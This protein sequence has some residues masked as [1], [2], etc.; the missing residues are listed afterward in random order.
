MAH[1]RKAA[2]TGAA[3]TNASITTRER[4][5]EADDVYIQSIN[6]RRSSMRAEFA[7]NLASVLD[8]RMM[9]QSKLVDLLND[10]FKRNKIENKAGEIRET[11]AWEV[12]RWA[13]GA[14]LPDSD[15]VDA[16]VAILDVKHDDL[17]VGLDAPLKKRLEVIHR[18]VA[19]GR[20]LWELRGVVD[21]ATHS[22]LLR[23][24]ADD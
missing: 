7:K 16:L 4:R 23:A 14:N 8:Q 9:K 12:S 11:A 17:V 3:T 6:A 24:L 20:Y 1:P 19:D 2:P 5:P 21:R 13:K 10:H 22:K 15:V 18:E